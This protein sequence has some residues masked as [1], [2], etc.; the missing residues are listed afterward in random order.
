MKTILMLAT[1]SSLAMTVSNSQPDDPNPQSPTP[2][3]S[4][5]PIKVKVQFTSNRWTTDK[6]LI[7]TGTLTNNNTTAVRVTQ[8]VA[9]GYDKDRK[10]VTEDS[11]LQ[12]PT[13]YTIENPEIAPG[14]AVIFKVALSDGKRVIRFVE[15]KPNLEPIP[16]STP[17]P[18]PASTP[19]A[20]MPTPGPVKAETPQDS[21]DSPPKAEHIANADIVDNALAYSK[22]LIPFLKTH[23]IPGRIPEERTLSLFRLLMHAAQSEGYDTPENQT[24]FVELVTRELQSAGIID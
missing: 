3:E 14:A 19:S 23:R 21:E 9:T 15:A 1:V 18:A 20:P 10:M 22:V 11:G 13:D 6:V 8:I 24:W 12:H 5:P 7:A 17:T 2:L 4:A 16:Q